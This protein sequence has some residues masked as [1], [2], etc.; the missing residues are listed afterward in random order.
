MKNKQLFGYLFL[1]PLVLAIWAGWQIFRSNTNPDRDAQAIA[2]IQTAITEMQ[3]MQRENPMQMLKYEGAA[4][5]MTP[6]VAL[7]FLERDL[8]SAKTRAL[9]TTIKKTLG[10]FS[11][12]SALAAM[13]IA[14][15]ILLKVKGASH[16][17]MKS[18]DHLL[19]AFSSTRHLLPLASTG[20]TVAIALSLAG[21]VIY[22]GMAV[23]HADLAD[24][25]RIKVVLLCGMLALA[26]LWLV[27]KALLS[28]PSAWKLFKPSP[29]PLFGQNLSKA[30][31]PGLWQW[32]DELSNTLGTSPPT[33]IIAGLNESFFV[34]SVSYELKPSGL[35]S[36]GKLLHL[37]LAEMSLLSKP[38]T[39]AIIGH[40]LGHFCGEDTAYSQRFIPIYAG[41]ENSLDAVLKTQK[42]SDG[43]GYLL[44]PAWLLGLWVMDK[45]HEAVM[46]WSRIREFAADQVGVK[47]AGAE[48]A[49]SALVRVVA[50][51]KPVGETMRTLRSA[52]EEI[53][54]NFL[55]SLRSEA[56]RHGFSDPETFLDQ[57]IAHPTD[58]HP[59]TRERIAK[60]GATLPL[61]PAFLEHALRRENPAEA[62]WLEPMF[63]DL[64]SLVQSLTGTLGEVIQKQ[65][66]QFEEEL[67]SIVSV[68]TESHTFYEKTL[69]NTILIGGLGLGCIV[70][71][72][73]AVV[74]S[75][76]GAD[77]EKLKWIGVGVVVLG[78]FVTWASRIYIKRGKQPFLEIHQA[79]FKVP[80]I[81]ELI[82]WKD[83]EDV[84]F[85]Q[86]KQIL[87]TTIQ[88]LPD[89]IFQIKK[90]P[91]R[92]TTYQK[93]RF[94]LHIIGG[95]PKGIK[96]Q[97]YV[98][99]IVAYFNS[100]RARE[101]QRI[102]QDEKAA[103]KAR[104]QEPTN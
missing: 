69:L 49:C 53:G 20:V 31:A 57:T 21:L 26:S 65:E 89:T 1:L 82:A 104:L 94:H 64:Q 100:G 71:G 76:L 80:G 13:V 45:F 24:R 51:S 90:D 48:A 6:N 52:P 77:P 79:G 55:K 44:R 8:K 93:K 61:S 33:H 73:I 27:V 60:M 5:S 10:P 98:D 96:V 41:V 56:H 11:L 67:S 47:A 40:E 25:A 88:L 101:I 84:N 15:L 70:G 16:T 37:P 4:Y 83:V 32:V 81:T 17:A 97:A 86:Q 50:V 12:V 2:S 14:T 3:E 38:E 34:T 36:E 30:E 18:R 43:V 35:I 102:R 42:G 72:I 29:K 19:R 63:T 59:P 95:K 74:N 92:R 7:T 66:A 68:S 58:S 46:H 87:T 103:V 22:E 39:A 75:R 62:T 99:L 9:E 85:A 23:V 54:G 78:L 91:L 28:L